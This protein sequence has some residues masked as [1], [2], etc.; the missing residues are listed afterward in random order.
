MNA[1]KHPTTEE[2]G[3][4]ATACTEAYTMKEVSLR[5]Q[6]LSD[7]IGNEW[8][9]IDTAGA[10]YA[11][12]LETSLTRAL[13]NAGFS[14]DVVVTYH[15]HLAGYAT[16]SLICDNTADQDQAEEILQQ[17]SEAA[18]NEFCSNPANNSL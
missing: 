14:A 10:A 17:V 8:N 1:P 5:L 2:A 7:S 11:Q 4:I 18:W 6:V 12:H 15:S 3:P 13:T 16:T 9:D